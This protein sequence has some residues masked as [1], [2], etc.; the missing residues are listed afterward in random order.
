MDL[1]RKRQDKSMNSSRHCSLFL[2]KQ[3]GLDPFFVPVDLLPEKCW[4]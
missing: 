1:V 4:K 3:L 2:A